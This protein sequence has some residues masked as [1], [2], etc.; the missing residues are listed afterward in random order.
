MDRL[1][2]K[3][4]DKKFLKY[5]KWIEENKASILSKSEMSLHQYDWVRFSVSIGL[6]DKYYGDENLKILELGGKGASTKLIKKFFPKWEIVN[7]DKDLRDPN[8]DLEDDSF[9]L[10]LNMEVVEHLTDQFVG[11]VNNPEYCYDYNA[12][13]IYS[14]VMNCMVE[15]NRVLKKEGHMFLTTPNIH[16]YIN[17][18]KMLVG[19]IPY[20]WPN[21]IR[22]YTYEELESII[23]KS[24]LKINDYECVEVLCAD[25]DFSYL[26]NFIKENKYQEGNRWSSFFFDLSINQRKK[27][28]L[29][30]QRFLSPLE[31][32]LIQ[33]DKEL[34]K[35]MILLEQQKVQIDE[36]RKYNESYLN[37]LDSIVNSFSWKIIGRL[38]NLIKLIK[39]KIKL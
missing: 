20:Q 26:E 31:K 21:H 28:K 22:E 5:Y 36:L 25:W 34:D 35:S 1:L 19:E 17:L 13:F 33:K 27:N 12:K 10:I 18:F 23:N 14:G 9:D 32:S 38:R 37:E 30:S 2:L 4:L 24:G 7:Y 11:L 29:G 15:C 6:L 39:Q 8:W 3:N 16:G